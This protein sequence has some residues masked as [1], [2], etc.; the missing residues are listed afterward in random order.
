M[1]ETMDTTAPFFG[2][3]GAASALVFSCAS[4][5]DRWSRLRSSPGGTS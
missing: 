1:A 5:P 2:F 4:P 3:L